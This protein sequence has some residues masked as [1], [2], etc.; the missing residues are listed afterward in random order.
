M[1]IV[2]SLA[3]FLTTKSRGKTAF[4]NCNIYF[5]YIHAYVYVCNFII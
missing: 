4:V 3:A 5:T 2:F 1:E